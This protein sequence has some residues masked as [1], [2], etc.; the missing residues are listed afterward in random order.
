MANYPSYPI[1]IDSVPRKENGADDEIA[2]TGT[3]HSRI[4]HSQQYYRFQ[5]KHPSLT[6]AQVDALDAL[7]AAGPRDTYTLTYYNVS[8]AVTY[9]VKF[10]SPPDIT[11]N[12][13]LGRF[14]VEVNLR[15]YK[16]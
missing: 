8:P 10:L 5:I 1:S 15:G 9:S 14:E 3:Q 4:F 12:H 11:A 16:D 13:G 6:Q 2:Q 7:Y